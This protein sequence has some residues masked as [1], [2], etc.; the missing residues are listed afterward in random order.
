MKTQ[1]T[2]RLSPGDRVDDL[3][4]LSDKSVSQKKNGDNYLSVVLSDKTGE[5]RGV[6]WDDADRI[7]GA[8]ASG[9]FV[10]VT[11]T[12][13]EYRGTLQITVRS[14]VRCDRESVDPGD[15][16]PM[17]ARDPKEMFDR[18]KRTVDENIKD[19]YLRRLLDLF[20]A[21]EEF[22]RRFKKA[23][24]AKKMHHAYLGA[25]WRIPSP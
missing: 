23:P 21:D 5:I 18:L 6:A 20:W 22:V 8:A 16:L 17:T 1:F 3:F 11:G 9:D 24:G 15:F 10:R 12:V 2:D 25:C 13:S 14:L 19:E 7:A 4:V